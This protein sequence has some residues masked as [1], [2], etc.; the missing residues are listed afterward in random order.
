MD[1]PESQATRL[2]VLVLKML[3]T[4]S[5]PSVGLGVAQTL[6]IQFLR[7]EAS[8]MSFTYWWGEISCTENIQKSLISQI[9]DRLICDSD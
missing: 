6:M 2:V 7:Q 9:A 1:F 8:H 4:G 3:P 5:V